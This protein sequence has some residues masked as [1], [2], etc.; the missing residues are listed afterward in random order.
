MTM[1]AQATPDAL[2]ETAVLAQATLNAAKAL[3]V[4]LQDLQSIIGKHPSNIRR[5]GL[6]PASK[7]GELALLLIRIYRGLYA[8]VGG[9]AAAMKHWMRT[10]NRDTGGIPAEQIRS[11]PGLLEVLVYLDAMRGVH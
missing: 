7:P 6:D 9:D 3:G 1:S 10:P 5:H 11:V 4:A 2:E 8:L